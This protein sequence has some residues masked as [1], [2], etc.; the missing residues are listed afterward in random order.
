MPGFL[1]FVATEPAT[2]DGV[3]VLANA[4]SGVAVGTTAEDLLGLLAEHEPAMPAPWVPVAVD[5]G[6]LA[7]TG[8]WYWGTSPSVLSMEG[9]RDLRLTAVGAGRSSRFRATGPDTWVG[10]DAYH[11]GET[12]RLVRDPAGRPQHLDLATFVHTRTPYPADGSV[13]G[14]VDPDGWVAPTG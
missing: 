13:P 10:L 6:L 3:V 2:G 14:G 12:L 1:A 4:T 11:A 9:R 5:A 7:L 8:T